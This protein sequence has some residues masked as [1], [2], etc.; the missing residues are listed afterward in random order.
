[1]GERVYRATLATDLPPIR[2][3]TPAAASVTVRLVDDGTVTV[4]VEADGAAVCR[5]GFAAEP[6]ERF[7]GFGERA[8]AVSL[9]RG[10]IEHYVG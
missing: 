10:V 2:P 1:M 9:E 3:G 8:H 5:Q 6:G 4:T 7:L